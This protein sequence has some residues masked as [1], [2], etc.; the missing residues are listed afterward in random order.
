L[1]EAYYTERVV[2]EFRRIIFNG[3]ILVFSDFNREHERCLTILKNAVSSSMTRRKIVATHHVRS[4]QIQC[5]K[6]AVSQDNGV[7]TVEL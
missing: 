6:F 3:D 7:F 5:P 2:S 4:F 1:K